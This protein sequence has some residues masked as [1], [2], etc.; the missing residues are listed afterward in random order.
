[1]S[2]KM[3]MGAFGSWW[4]VLD[5]VRGWEVPRNKLHSFPEHRRSTA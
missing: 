3:A 5:G 4:C 1:M 2:T